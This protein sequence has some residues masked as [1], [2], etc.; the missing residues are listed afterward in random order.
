M[1]HKKGP[2]EISPGRHLSTGSRDDGHEIKDAEHVDDGLEDESYGEICCC[3][4]KY[5]CCFCQH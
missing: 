5:I 1:T 4:C 2:V 3:L